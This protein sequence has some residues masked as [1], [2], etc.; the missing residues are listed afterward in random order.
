MADD[1]LNLCLFEICRG[2]KADLYRSSPVDA[3]AGYGL[4][5]DTERA[6]AEGDVETVL[7]RGGHPILT[8]YL[9]RMHG[10]TLADYKR[11]VERVDS[12]APG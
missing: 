2:P 9:G 4:D 6:V 3:V 1:L 12:G 11:A 8:M 5:P 10:M 7:R